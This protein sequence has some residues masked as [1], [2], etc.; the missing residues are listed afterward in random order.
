MVLL[1]QQAV[2]ALSYAAGHPA[3]VTDLLDEWR[4]HSSGIRSTASRDRTEKEYALFV[5]PVWLVGWFFTGVICA[6]LVFA[7]LEWRRL[8]GDGVGGKR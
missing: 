4:T 3:A 8:Q 5:P 2:P 7:C 1:Q 6:E